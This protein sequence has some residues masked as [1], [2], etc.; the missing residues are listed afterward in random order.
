MR[1]AV[2]LADADAAP[3]PRIFCSCEGTSL[4]PR[5]ERRGDGRLRDRAGPRPR[6][7]ALLP[8][9]SVR[10]RPLPTGGPSPP[11]RQW[12]DAPRAVPRWGRGGRRARG[13][14]GVARSSALPAAALGVG[15]AGCSASRGTMGE[16]AGARH[17]GGGG[18]RLRGGGGGGG[19]PWCRRRRGWWGRAC[20]R[21]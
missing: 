21:R 2:Q 15:R 16:S 5:A 12:G 4:P 13:G 11:T 3:L 9:A 20:G 17:G 19:R 18:G 10:R 1:G 6:P 7:A 14:E 8:A